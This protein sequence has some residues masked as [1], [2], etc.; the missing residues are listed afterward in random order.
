MTQQTQWTWKV[1]KNCTYVTVTD[2]TGRNRAT[3]RRYPKTD[4]WYK[5]ARL[6]NVPF[7]V[8]SEEFLRVKPRTGGVTGRRPTGNQWATFV[9]FVE[10]E[11]YD[12]LKAAGHDVV[13]TF[14]LQLLEEF[15]PQSSRRMPRKANN[16]MYSVCSSR[17]NVERLR[18]LNRTNRA[19]LIDQLK[20]AFCPEA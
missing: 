13:K 12:A 17:E 1:A 18:E 7:T 6:G 11:L 15:V 19:W 20:K 16:K 14:L 9:L 4:I 3:F 5:I 10:P 8:Y 2:D